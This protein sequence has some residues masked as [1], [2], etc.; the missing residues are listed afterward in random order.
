MVLCRHS[1]GSRDFYRA[2]YLTLEHLFKPEVQFKIIKPRDGW[3][4]PFC[5]ESSRQIL[6]V[7]FQEI[8]IGCIIIGDQNGVTLYP[9]VA[10]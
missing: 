9:D 6:V 10:L 7:L 5:R 2:I 4:Y 1:G 3:F 8:G